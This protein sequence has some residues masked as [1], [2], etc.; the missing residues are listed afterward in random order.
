VI[1]PKRDAHF[2]P[3]EGSRSLA[4]L[5]A[6]EAMRFDVN[7]WFDATKPGTYR[8]RVNLAADSGIGEGWSN[9][10]YFQIS[11]DD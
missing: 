5:E 2:D 11:G 1:E 9:E 10:A 6:F 8:L 4:P 3:G 7:D